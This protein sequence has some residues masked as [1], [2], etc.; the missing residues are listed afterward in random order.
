MKKFAVYMNKDATQFYCT[1]TINGEKRYTP[2]HD[3][4][5]RKQDYPKE[6]DFNEFYMWMACEPKFYRMGTKN[7]VQL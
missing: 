4:N 2:I 5:I 7:G 6:S 1:Q 3:F